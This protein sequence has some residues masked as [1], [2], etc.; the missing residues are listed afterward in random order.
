MIKVSILV[1]V[2]NGEK[3]IE[4]CLHSLVNQTYKNIEIVCIDDCSSDRSVELIERMIVND[5]R[6]KLLKNTENKGAAGARN[7][8]LQAC[9]GDV[10]GYLDCDDIYAPDTVEKLVNVFETHEDADCVLYR[11]VYVDSE[12]NQKEYK[13]LQFD[14]L[15]GTDAFKESLTWNIHGVYAA[16]TELFRKFQYDTTRRHFSDDN[17]TRLHYYISRKVYQSDAPYYYVYNPTSISNQIS[18]SRMDYLAATQSMK[19]QLESLNCSEDIM[20][21]YENVRMKVVVDCYLFYYKYRNRLSKDEKHYCLNELKTGWES[22]DEKLLEKS[23]SSKFGYM[24]LKNNW[25]LFRLQEELYFFIKK[26]TGKL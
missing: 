25:I 18:V 6:I 17:T 26:I 15:S 24:P 22:I 2:Y 3:F 1:A 23:L 19:L 21:L 9:T 5:S 4:K 20:R 13:G 10:I 11:C 8:G 14:S 7:V 16:R 12:G